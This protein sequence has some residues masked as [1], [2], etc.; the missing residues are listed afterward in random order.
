MMATTEI[1]KVPAPFSPGRRSRLKTIGVKQIADQLRRY[2]RRQGF[3]STTTPLLVAPATAACAM[4][5]RP[6]LWDR[7]RGDDDHGRRRRGCWDWCGA[8]S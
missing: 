4:R 7:V 6:D 3:R 8:T 1:D 5:R 2:R